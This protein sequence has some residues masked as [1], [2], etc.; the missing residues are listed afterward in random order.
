MAPEA[1]EAKQAFI[2]DNALVLYFDNA[3][4]PFVARLDLDSLA[5][6]N[7]EVTDKKDGTHALTLRDFS[8]QVQNIG[9]FA[10]KADAH[11]ALYAIL[12]A[13]LS[14]KAENGQGG[15]CA[16]G[17]FVCWLKKLL[18]VTLWIIGILVVLY[19]LLG[20]I[21][22]RTTEPVSD[23]ADAPVAATQDATSETAPAPQQQDAPLSAAPE[24]EA[25]DADA[26]LGNVQDDTTENTEEDAAVPATD[27]AATDDTAE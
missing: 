27:A 26:V 16:R 17:G 23:K 18:K 14:Y 1:K 25:V 4:T 7:F 12:Q 22:V 8:G 3:E 15:S 10:T 11:Q 24:G 13:L 20:L 2:R 6:A 5:Q 21:P 19:I 9:L